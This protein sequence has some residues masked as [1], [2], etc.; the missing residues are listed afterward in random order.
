[1]SSTLPELEKVSS[2][3]TKTT[4]SAKK[5]D[6]IPQPRRSSVRLAIAQLAKKEHAT[7]GKEEREEEKLT[8]EKGVERV[9]GLQKDNSA[10]RVKRERVKRERVKKEKGGGVR[11]VEGAKRE[12]KGEK[13]QTAKKERGVKRER[14]VKKER[15]SKKAKKLDSQEEPYPKHSF[16]TNEMCQIAV[17]SLTKLHGK[18]IRGEPNSRS[19]LDSLVGTML[20][21]NTTDDTSARAFGNLKSR[22]PTWEDARMA[23][24]DDIE[25]EIR[26]CGLS[27]IRAERIKSILNKVYDERKGKTPRL[28]MEYVRD[29]DNQAVK[30]EL[31][32]FKGVGPK[33]AACVLM[34]NLQRPEFPVDTHVWRICK[35]LGW[36]PASCTREQCYEHMNRR[37]PD[38]LKY[39]LHCLLVG[40][41]KRCVKCAKNNKPR[42]EVAG[43]CPLPKASAKASKKL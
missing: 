29:M 25:V 9:M 38:N 3:T 4:R 10:E 27:K 21:Q 35:Q 41:G 23:H 11:K 22:F 28:S 18:I 2:K 33:T 40:H 19:V 39:E 13:E 1:M 30:D 43:E 42:K 8:K 36:V 31:C 16:P 17:N 26:V 37:V 12:L 14:G 24:E 15:S 6:T 32:R 7:L 20:S 5:P 34:F